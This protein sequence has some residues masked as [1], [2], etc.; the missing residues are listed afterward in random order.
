MA[1][2]GDGGDEP[3]DSPGRNLMVD[4]E[5]LFEQISKLRK[6]KI[7]TATDK[8]HGPVFRLVKWPIL[9]VSCTAPSVVCPN[10]DPETCRDPSAR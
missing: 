2:G 7:D 6:D 1:A 8:A 5:K 3:G 10:P 9:V 4:Q